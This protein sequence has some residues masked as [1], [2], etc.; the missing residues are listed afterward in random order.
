MNISLQTLDMTKPLRSPLRLPLRLVT[1]VVLVMS[2]AL[3]GLL[4]SANAQDTGRECARESTATGVLTCASAYLVNGSAWLDANNPDLTGSL[5]SGAVVL[6]EELIETYAGSQVEL[7]FNEGSV[8]WTKERTEFEFTPE[9][10][11]IDLVDGGVLTAVVPGGDPIT[12]RTAEL[13]TQPRGTV[14][15]VE[16]DQ[17]SGQTNVFA[18]TDN[19]N[20][21]LR[22]VTPGGEVQELRSGEFVSATDEGFID[23]GSFNLVTFYANRGY[24]RGFGPGES[25]AVA[26]RPPSVQ[27]TI[28]AARVETLAAVENQI[29]AN[30]R[31]FRG[32][33]VSDALT[34]ADVDSAFDVD[35]RLRDFI[36]PGPGDVPIEGRFLLVEINEDE[37]T[38]F[39]V[40]TPNGVAGPTLFI[41]FDDGVATFVD[42]IA[43]FNFP[44]S[45]VTFGGGADSI[46]GEVGNVGFAEGEGTASVTTSRGVTLDLGGGNIIRLEPGESIQIDASGFG[47]NVQRGD[48]V[49]AVIMNGI[50]PDT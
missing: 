48:N 47:G 37:S 28:N 20:G 44:T 2:P 40:F 13:E 3:G 9:L 21:P 27:A 1:S 42:G 12:V 18:L 30:S 36:E 11:N 10:R 38:G 7:E 17:R 15:V 5:T 32:T 49:D 22:V 8:A 16:R 43:S 35:V 41:N 19:E 29:Q 23:S 50:I 45:T 14:Y 46:S 31:G 34:G 33:F 39:G 26:S 4:S 6:P 24:P 25:S